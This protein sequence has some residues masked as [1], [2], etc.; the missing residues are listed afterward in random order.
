LAKELADDFEK[1][2][3]ALKQTFKERERNLE[4]QEKELKQKILEAGRTGDTA[5]VESL[6]QQLGQIKAQKELIELKEEEREKAIEQEEERIEEEMKAKEKAEK[7]ILEA[8][9]EKQN[10]IDEASEKG[11][12]VPA[13]VFSRFDD[14]LNQAKSAF[15][16]GNYQESKRLARQAEES[17][18]A[19]EKTIEDLEKVKEKDEELKEEQEREAKEKKEELKYVP[20]AGT[21]KP[22]IPS[23]G[24]ENVE[25][26]IKVLSPNGGEQ[27]KIGE[28][29]NIK[30]DSAGVSKIYVTLLNYS[31]TDS[32][33]L[34]YESIT[35]TGSYSFNTGQQGRCPQ[36]V[37]I[38]DK[39]KIEIS[40]DVYTTNGVEIKDES[41]NYFS[42]TAQN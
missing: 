21:P 11:L 1:P 31:Q 42:I 40:A 14:L 16:A 17:L 22:E 26:Y 24:K 39:I 8:G 23:K 4:T 10:L 20:K 18:D 6:V 27:W 33:R 25:P 30:W 36:S 2:K 28:T 37:F 3:L 12:T 35:N 19:A 34:T 5:R 32:C 38:G 9:G 13:A 41:D 29:Y 15:A 7:A